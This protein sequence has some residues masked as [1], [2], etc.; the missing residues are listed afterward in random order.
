MLRS[1]VQGLTSFTASA[2]RINSLITG[3]Q[4]FS[5]PSSYSTCIS[6]DKL[7]P[8][9]RKRNKEEENSSFTFIAVHRPI[10]KVSPTVL[11][12]FPVAYL[13]RATATRFATENCALSYQLRANE[14]TD[15]LKSIPTRFQVLAP[16]MILVTIYN[17]LFERKLA[18]TAMCVVLALNCQD[19]NIL[20]LPPHLLETLIA[21]AVLVNSLKA[22]PLPPSSQ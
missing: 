19:W 15:V 18:L 2:C 12:E 8:E 9:Q 22:L 14:S 7:S 11:H 13:Q 1:L 17:E 3:K 20:L 4:Q 6:L 10:P 16:Q 21:P 5:I